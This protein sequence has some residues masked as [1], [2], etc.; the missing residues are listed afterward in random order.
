VPRVPEH[1]F[2]SRVSNKLDVKRQSSQYVN[3]SAIVI[4]MLAAGVCGTDLAMIGGAR[5]CRAEVLGHE[6]VGVVVSCPENSGVAKGARVIINPVHRK[7]PE[8]VIGHSRDGVFREVFC[9][10]TTDAVQGGLLVECRKE[11]SIG[12]EDLALAEPIASV[13]Y[14]FELLRQ[15][16][17]ADSLL[18]RGSGTIGVLAATLWPTFGGS[19][20]VLVSTSE[21]HA[22]WLRHACHWPENV[23]ITSTEA[24]DA[25]SRGT[26]GAG[27][28]SAILCSSRHDA[29]QGFHFLMDSVG[30]SARIDL[31]A[32]FPAEYRE[33]RLGG[34]DLDRI[35]WNNICGVQSGSATTAID[36]RT[37]K[38]LTL[39]GHR[40]TS[41]R[42]ILQAVELLSRRTISL[43][44]LPHRLLTLE[45]L[46][47]A[48]NEMLP[49]D[50][51]RN[52]KWIKAIV[53]FPQEDSGEAH[54]R[55]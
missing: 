35:R 46:P 28:D 6:G 5:P 2:V 47:A 14:S 4:K 36:R 32:G 37:G 9:L 42:H 54:G 34:V 48:V 1:L 43:A 49:A 38:T 52:T 51:R 7:Q 33:G 53:T 44:N 20:A 18:I 21:E 19:S 17:S 10:E 24:S 31:M 12:S 50:T 55:G 15:N 30:E 25:I 27:F 22:R 40:G 11:C 8:L 29:P 13:L 41:E 3:D 26:P 23:R 39:L 45:E 16:R